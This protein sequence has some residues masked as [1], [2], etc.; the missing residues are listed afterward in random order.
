MNASDWPSDQEVRLQRRRTIKRALGISFIGFIV[1]F[2][3]A[4]FGLHHLG[5]SLLSG[6]CAN[7]IIHRSVQPTGSLELVAFQRNC[8]ATTG[9]SY[10]LSILQQGS[11]SKQSGNV[12]I[13][14]KPFKAEWTGPSSIAVTGDTGGALKKRERY[15]KIHIRY[16]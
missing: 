9:Y 11:G 7:E 6:M 12:F 4:A 2:G 10:Q 1:L 14:T 13:S 16:N 3:M 8:G 5:G 15:R